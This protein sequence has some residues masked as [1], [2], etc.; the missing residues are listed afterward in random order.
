[1][2]P[3]GERDVRLFEEGRKEESFGDGM[4]EKKQKVARYA[5]WRTYDN[6]VFSEKR[7]IFRI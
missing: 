2:M 5:D 4:E 6:I 3:R 7:T 1:M